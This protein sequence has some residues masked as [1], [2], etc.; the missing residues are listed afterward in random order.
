M[1]F[2]CYFYVISRLFLPQPFARVRCRARTRG[3]TCT[4]AHGDSEVRHPDRVQDGSGDNTE[5]RRQP[6]R[7]VPPP[8]ESGPPTPSATESELGHIPRVVPPPAKSGPVVP[9][10]SPPSLPGPETVVAVS[11]PGASVA[12]Q[13]AYVADDEGAVSMT[14]EDPPAGTDESEASLSL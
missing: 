1:L 2:L 10:C 13:G 9:T 6:P 11:S 4:F 7:V 5:L 3:D 14:E 8:V 12:S